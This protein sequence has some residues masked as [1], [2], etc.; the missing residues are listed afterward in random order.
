MAP[1]VNKRQQRELEELETLAGHSNINSTDEEET[2]SLSKGKSGTSGF[3]A[4][5]SVIPYNPVQ[6]LKFTL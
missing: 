3:A 2:V 5:C 1:R 6:I 4:V